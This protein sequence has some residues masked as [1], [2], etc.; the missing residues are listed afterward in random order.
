MYE[1]NA[2]II[3]IVDGDSVKL[4]VDLGLS[5]HIHVAVRLTG[6]NAPELSTPA[7]KAAKA[8][9]E[10]TVARL[11]STVQVR[12][13]KADKYGRYLAWVTWPGSTDLSLNQ[14]LLSSGNAVPWDGKGQRPT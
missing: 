8:F 7:G 13:M 10:A 5:V 14:Q 6:L 9:V 4:N 1:Y 11:G 3:S 12:T 2:E